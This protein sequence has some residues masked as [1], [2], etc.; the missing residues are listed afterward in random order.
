M[1]GGIQF[2]QDKDSNF[3]YSFGCAKDTGVW[4]VDNSLPT[5]AGK[6]FIKNGTLIRYPKDFREKNY[7]SLEDIHKMLIRLIFPDA[8]HDNISFKIDSSFRTELIKA[9]GDFPRE[10]Q[11]SEYKLEK[12]PDY[13]YKFFV[14]PIIMSTKN[15]NIRIYNKV[16]I[17]SGFISDISYISDEKN[18]VQ[19]FI[20]A[21]MLA[22]EDN[23]MDN[24][25][26][27]YFDIDKLKR[28]KFLY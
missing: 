15:N 16:G 25:K 11:N 27:N 21:S 5:T 12:I 14:D 17:A 8:F 26:N 3:V 20:S 10:L 9:M 22:K 2:I 19:Y 23:I 13:Y 4:K 1:H 28:G 24:G 18:N 7:V 6:S